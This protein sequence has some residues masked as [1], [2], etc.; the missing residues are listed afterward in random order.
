MTHRIA[1]EEIEQI[2]RDVDLVVLARSYGIEP[3]PQGKHVLAKCPFHPEETASFSITPSVN[4]YHC[5]GCGAAGS[6][7]DFVM[8]MEGMGF[9][10]A[11]EKLRGEITRLASEG[12]SS[13][14]RVKKVVKEEE[15][16]LIRL[17]CE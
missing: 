12:V 5:F 14:I 11:V 4:L 13:P 16:L 7:I 10:E 9:V 1:E 15:K 8:K 2:K 17:T 3:K 6:P